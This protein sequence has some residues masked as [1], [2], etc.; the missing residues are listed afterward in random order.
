MRVCETA[1]IFK[2]MLIE[3][4]CYLEFTL[5]FATS[6]FS[7]FQFSLKTWLFSVYDH[8][9]CTSGLHSFPWW[10]HNKQQTGYV[11]TLPNRQTDRHTYTRTN[12]QV[13]WLANHNC[14]SVPVSL[15]SQIWSVSP[16]LLCHTLHNHMIQPP[17]TPCLSCAAVLDMMGKKVHVEF[18]IEATER[19]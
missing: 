13:L 5:F 9:R 2:Y 8:C 3:I 1:L 14:I 6:Q 10:P 17:T 11:L 19:H 16:Y 15:V 18:K 4:Y 12:I 7:K